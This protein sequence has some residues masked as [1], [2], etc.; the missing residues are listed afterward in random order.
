M[1]RMRLS[2]RARVRAALAGAAG[3]TVGIALGGSL[4]LG[5]ANEA[6]GDAN[7]L[8]SL[9]PARL[10]D[11]THVPPL[12]TVPGEAVTLRYDVY[13]P[14]PEGAP[15]D[16][17]DGDGTV[18]ARAGS[19]GPFRA[20][21]LQRDGKASAGR[22]FAR[23]PDAIASSPAGFSYYAVLRN[24][25][26]GAAMTLPPGG[27]SAPQRSYRAA[28]AV[29]VD[30]GAHRFGAPRSPSK[31]VLDIRWGDGLAEAGLEGGPGSTPV[32]P[33]AFAVAADGTVTLLDQ[34]H[35]RALELRP[36]AVAASAVPLAV[37]GTL[38][39]LAVGPG[40][41]LWVLE[42]AG[43]GAPLL[44]A[45]TPRGAPERVVPLADRTASQLRIAP[46]GPVVK[47]LPSE[48][49]VPAV[50]DG[51][52]LGA[53]AQELAA[54][55]ARPVSKARDV[56]VLRTGDE[57]RVALVGAAGVERAWRVRSSTPLGEIQ[58]AE[59][60]GD[61][62]VLVLR[63]YT[64]D[65]SEFTVARLGARGL[66]G[67][68]AVASADWAETAPLSRFRLAGSSVYRLGSTPESVSIDRFDLEVR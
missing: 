65:R 27:A 3:L 66:A 20:F 38:A 26:N 61:G 4:L 8:P 34:V 49:W 10:I 13:C 56:V 37:N 23:L 25:A 33:G 44:R 50:E 11:A 5:L 55:S 30:L 35:R 24:R 36:G 68:F 6:S 54:E 63:S 1:E 41:D 48:Q 14:P 12:I 17:C 51:V 59:P 40:G 58:L 46:A 2:R 21:P 39:D 18:Y 64:D 22:Y 42:T 43:R 16:A 47:Q 9:D 31:R 62:V 29:D 67:T 19:F 53:R 45:F 28:S 7:P 57:A 60:Y 15:T 32:G 52:A